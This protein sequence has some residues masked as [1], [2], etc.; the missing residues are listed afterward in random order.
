MRIL[1][2]DKNSLHHCCCRQLAREYFVRYPRIDTTV[3]ESWREA[4]SYNI[5]FIGRTARADR[6]P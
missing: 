6:S 1:T 3:V 2:S 5:E 4:R